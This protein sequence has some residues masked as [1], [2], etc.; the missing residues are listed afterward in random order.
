MKK[1]R[2][3]SVAVFQEVEKEGITLSALA[4]RIGRSQGAMSQ[5]FARGLRASPDTM[6][7]LS[8]GWAAPGAGARVLI[9]HLQDEIDRSGWSV[10]DYRVK[11]RPATGAGASSQLDKDLEDLRAACEFVPALACLVS[12][13]LMVA[14]AELPAGV[15]SA[16]VEPFNARAADPGAAYVTKEK[17]KKSAT[18]K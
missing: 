6:R 14:R 16:G 7:V 1:A 9:A 2:R 17:V 12:D 3:L 5:L 4:A 18:D 11:Y 15:L 10:S 8:R 13:V